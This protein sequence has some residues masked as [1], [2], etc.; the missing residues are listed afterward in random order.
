M[1][2]ITERSLWALA[3]I[4]SYLTL[5]S[6]FTGRNSS[7][8]TV[9]Q[10]SILQQDRSLEV[11]DDQKPPKV[12]LVEGHWVNSGVMQYTPK[13]GMFDYLGMPVETRE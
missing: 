11:V 1:R 13:F 5:K 8:V 4:V 7:S 10:S 2:P 9:S 6:G 3:I 12:A